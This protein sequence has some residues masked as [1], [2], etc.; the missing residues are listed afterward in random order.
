M[1][2]KNEPFF[3]G[4]WGEKEKSRADEQQRAWNCYNSGNV[5]WFRILKWRFKHT[6][7]T[8]TIGMITYSL[9]MIWGH[10]RRLDDFGLPGGD[11]Q[12]LQA[13]HKSCTIDPGA[14]EPLFQHWIF[15]LSWC[16][17]S[18]NQ[19]EWNRIQQM[20][21]LYHFSGHI[22]LGYSLKF[23]PYIGL[24][25]GRYLQF[26]FLNLGCLP[27]LL[28]LDL[29]WIRRIQSLAEHPA[30]VGDRPRLAAKKLPETS[31]IFGRDK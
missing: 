13:N 14:L 4:K 30:I 2:Y 18:F 10:T 23:R 11:H 5:I 24:I 22:L 27:N 9:D 7:G 20:E 17:A 12:T 31:L 25:Y 16:I 8:S 19:W 1:R 28:F 6:W 26:R 29:G 15:S 3:T 21:V